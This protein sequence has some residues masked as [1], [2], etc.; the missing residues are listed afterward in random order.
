MPCVIRPGEESESESEAR[1]HLPTLTARVQESRTVRY[2]LH[3]QRSLRVSCEPWP[4]GSGWV[5]RELTHNDPQKAS[6]SR[7]TTGESSNDS[8]NRDGSTKLPITICTLGRQSHETCRITT[9]II[10]IITTIA[11]ITILFTIT[12]KRITFLS[13]SRYEQTAHSPT[14]DEGHDIRAHLTLCVYQKISLC[15]PYSFR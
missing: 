11:T 5:A 15:T 7:T 10:I 9:T 6:P 1:E 3:T 13:F 2:L 14:V 8:P 4:T 12:T